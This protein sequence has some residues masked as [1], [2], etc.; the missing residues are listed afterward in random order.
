MAKTP[1]TDA[2]AAAAA[3]AAAAD[4]AATAAAKGR[5]TPT[6]KEQEAA[7]KQPL[8]P[9]DRRLAARQ[10]R[11]KVAADRERARV[12]MANGEEKYL[13]L[14]DKG[15]QK[16]YVRD[17]IDAR[18]SIG[19]LLLPIVALVF[20]TWF[21]PPG[22]QDIAVYVTYSFL[23]IVV[24][25]AVLLGFRLTRKLGEKFGKDR[26][27]KIRWYAFM[28]AIQLRPIRLP[29]PQVKRGEFPK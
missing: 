26:V 29:K 13:P 21:L 19:E 9:T 25:D 7:R 24:A 2:A 8:V 23:L 6:R 11:D 14:R 22:V 12:G 18:F 17:Y 27:E 4:A 16:R 1:K 15:P 28:R 5:P 10:S 20:L 3:D